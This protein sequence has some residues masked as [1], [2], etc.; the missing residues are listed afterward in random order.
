MGKKQN[1]RKNV[2]AFAVVFVLS[3]NKNETFIGRYLA[4]SCVRGKI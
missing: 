4:F 2:I 1:R 3:E